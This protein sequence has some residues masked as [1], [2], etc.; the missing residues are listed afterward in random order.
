MNADKIRVIRVHPRPDSC[1]SRESQEVQRLMGFPAN[2]PS[3][4]LSAFYDGRHANARP[5]HPSL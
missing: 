4:M 2:P 1:Q 3:V 5:A